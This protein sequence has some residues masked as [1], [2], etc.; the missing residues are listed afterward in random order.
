M[1]LR[2]YLCDDLL[3][4]REEIKMT[5]EEWHNL[6]ELLKTNRNLTEISLF[7]IESGPEDKKEAWL[8]SLSE[9]SFYLSQ[10][11]IDNYFVIG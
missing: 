10:A 7:I 4:F 9:E 11:I 5:E 3:L 6:T 8:A 2:A 1:Y